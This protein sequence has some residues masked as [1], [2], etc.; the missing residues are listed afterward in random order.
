MSGIVQVYGDYGLSGSTL[1]VS[2]IPVELY[3]STATTPAVM[4][5]P[6]GNLTSAT[7]NQTVNDAKAV[8]PTHHR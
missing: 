8:E 5:N 3:T 6:S 2:T 4:S 7:V 1:D